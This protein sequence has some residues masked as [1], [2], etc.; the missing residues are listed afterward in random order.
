MSK[1]TAARRKPERQAPRSYDDTAAAPSAAVTTPSVGGG[2]GISAGTQSASRGY[3]YF[4]NLK[5]KYHFARAPRL[6]VIK[7]CRWLSYNDGDGRLLRQI[8]D[9]IGP[10]TVQPATTDAEWNE[11]FKALWD[12]QYV[13]AYNYDA[14]GKFTAETYQSMIH[15]LMDRDGDVL[16]VFTEKESGEPTVALYDSTS[17]SDRT[18]YG[19]SA[20]GYFDGVKVDRLNRHLAYSLI[21]ED[22]QAPPEI[23]PA[24]RAFIFSH[25]ETPEA[26]RGTPALIHAADNV[27]D[28]RQINNDIKKRLMIQGL[29][30]MALKSQTATLPMKPVAG[31]MVPANL[32]ASTITGATSDTD[33]VPRYKE[34][35]FDGAGIIRLP[36]GAEM[37]FLT[38]DRDAPSQKEI[39]DDIY[40][41]IARGLGVRKE[42]LYMIDQLTG[43]GVRF[44][45]ADVQK[46]RDRRLNRMIPFV[47][48][49]YARRVEW[50]LRTRQIC[51]PRDPRYW[52]CTYTFP[53]AITIDAG[54]DNAGRI[55]SL[56]NG[57][58]T[59]QEEYGQQGDQWAPQTK[60]RIREIAYAID[61][62]AAAA[63]TDHDRKE[64]I[65]R[66]YFAGMD[67][68]PAA[69]EP[70]D[71][72]ASDDDAEDT[73]PVPA[74]KKPKQ[75]PNS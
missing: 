49:D 33:T 41:N 32:P 22:Y 37:D 10:V 64:K 61:E 5:A 18:A 39:K 4:P 6:E 7:K 51:P 54:R 28:I 63:G 75:N 25:F 38:D 68:A 36:G 55:A 70:P 17:I 16:N 45:I 15:F 53:A 65:E 57:L 24:S 60:Q 23:V 58:T 72:A 3:V 48:L 46:W 50:M 19:Q 14:S 73:P 26:V 62:C 21:G 47:K 59:L 8:A 2:A 35:I 71:S 27:L 9:W 1:R 29:F 11:E 74:P 12:E 30:G 20:P 69:P 43:P 67:L 66:Y 40:G 34:E 52:K 31:K 42:F 56:K 13:E 44:V